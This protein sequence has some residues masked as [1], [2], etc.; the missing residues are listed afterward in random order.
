MFRVNMVK[1]M[2]SDGVACDELQLIQMYRSDCRWC[3]QQRKSLCNKLIQTEVF[4]FRRDGYVM[5]VTSVLSV[6]QQQSGAS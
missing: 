3:F 2:N 1:D 5:K 6:P 4:W